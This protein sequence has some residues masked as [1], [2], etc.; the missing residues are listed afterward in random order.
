M[1]YAMPYQRETL[2][3]HFSKAPQCLIIDDVSKQ[4]TLVDLPPQAQEGNKRK[5]W[6]ALFKRYHVQAVIVRNIGENMLKFLLDNEINIYAAQRG[7]DIDNLNSA[8]LQSVTE[9]SFARPSHSEGK[10]CQQ[11][12]LTHSQKNSRLFARRVA[13]IEGIHHCIAIKGEDK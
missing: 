8:A 1:I 12:C 3:N 5:L 6:M 9:L 2:S 4:R 10:K 7:F 13:K 11:R